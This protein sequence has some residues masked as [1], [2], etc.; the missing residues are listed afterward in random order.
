MV[1]NAN[2]GIVWGGRVIVP[3]INKIIQ[4]IGLFSMIKPEAMTNAY[5][6]RRQVSLIL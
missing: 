5:A 1:V 4:L 6:Q 2:R 3:K